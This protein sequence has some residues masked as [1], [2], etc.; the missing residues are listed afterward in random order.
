MSKA[1]AGSSTPVTPAWYREVLGQYPT[2][3]A[4]VTAIDA[5]QAPVG[6]AV[7][8]FTSV[9][10]E[11]PLVGFLPARTSRSWPHIE[12]AG[13]FCINILGADQEDVCRIFAS[14]ETD[15]FR[16]LRWRAAGSGSPIIEGSVAWIDCD[17]ESAHDARDHVMVVGRVGRLALERPAARL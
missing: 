4:V 5:D 16:D 13:R 12:A 1:L 6:L 3:V 17:L 7:G 11:P 9:S 10:L 14:K 8:T 2:G 15:K